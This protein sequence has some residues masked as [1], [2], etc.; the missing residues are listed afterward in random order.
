MRAF[1]FSVD[2]TEVHSRLD[3]YLADQLP[4]VSRSQVQRLIKKGFVKVNSKSA[5]GS[6]KLNKN[7][8]VEVILPEPEAWHVNPEKGPLDVVYEDSDL[9]VINKEVGVVV[10]PAP[11]HRN[12]TLV[13]FL[14]EHCKALS[15]IGGVLRPGVVHRLDQG[16]SGLLVFAKN[17]STHRGLAKQFHDHTI[18]R[19]Y[20]ALV[21]GNVSPDSGKIEVSIGRSPSD[22][23]KMA[24]VSEGKPAI[25]NWKVLERYP[26]LCLLELKLETGRT[27]QIRVHL[28]SKGWGVVGDP[29]Y[30]GSSKRINSIND[31]TISSALKQ[32]K[33]PLLHAKRLGFIHPKT[34]E[35]LNFEREVPKE[36]QRILELLCAR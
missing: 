35:H 12:G 5:K 2:E 28:N 13:N 20:K 8:Q 10:H 34:G 36:F 21:F 3:K 33:H 7:D 27:H 19:E 24:A 1:Q 23:K 25:T 29:V 18:N 32:I 16:T 15:G 22:R 9:I 4:D 11:G 26:S 17:D 30:G 31:S 6:Y 14:L